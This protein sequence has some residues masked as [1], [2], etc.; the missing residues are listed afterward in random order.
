[1]RQGIFY[2]VSV[3]PGDPELLTLKAVRVLKSCPVLAVPQTGAGRTAALDIVRGAVDLR[4]KTLLMLHFSMRGDAAAMQAAHRAMAAQIAEHLREGRDVALP[5]LGDVS[6][7]STFA[8]LQKEVEAAG[9]SAVMVPGVPSF[10]AAAAALNRPL[11]EPAL[12]LHLLPGGQGDDGL[13]GT[14]IY[15]KQGASLPALVEKLYRQG[16]QGSIVLNCGMEN[17]RIFRSL[18]EYDG[19]TDYFALLVVRE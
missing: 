1:M 7:Y 6:I 12:P 8:A 14:R 10:C 11:T 9:F 18:S 13:T 5:N 16:K 17:E 4:G 3:G 2:G 15:M 19:S